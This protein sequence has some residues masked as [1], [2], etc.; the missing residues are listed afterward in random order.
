[1]LSCSLRWFGCGDGGRIPPRGPDPRIGAL[2][3][4]RHIARRGAKRQSV[5]RRNSHAACSSATVLPACMRHAWPGGAAGKLAFERHAANGRR[6]RMVAAQR[7]FLRCSRSAPPPF[8]G[9]IEAPHAGAGRGAACHR[10]VRR[11]PG[12]RGGL[13]A[14]R[15]RR[16]RGQ[17]GRARF[18]HA[19][20]RSATA[21]PRPRSRFRTR[22]TAA[23]LRRWRSWRR[24]GSGDPARLEAIVDGG[25]RHVEPRGRPGVPAGARRAR[26]PTS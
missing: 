5:P 14:A 25:L 12:G 18:R 7:V 16:R 20:P 10:R 22:S 17:V 6:G 19:A 24:R 1:M 26:R 11:R 8:R 13:P 4:S 2:I 9:S 23:S 15:A 21:S 3:I